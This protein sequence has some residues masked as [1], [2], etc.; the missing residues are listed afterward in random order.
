MS[1]RFFLTAAWLGALTWPVLG[2]AAAL[3]L[4]LV[5][6]L[7]PAALG[8]WNALRRAAVVP[9]RGLWAALEAAS[10]RIPPRFQIWGLAAFLCVAPLFLRHQ[11]KYINL[12]TDTLIMVLLALGLNIVLGMAGLFMLGYAAFYA[13][14]AYAFAILSLKFQVPFW[15]GLVAGAAAAALVG[16]VV[17]LPSLRLRGDYLAIVTLGLGETIRYII[18]NEEWLTGGTFGC[19]SRPVFISFGLEPYSRKIGS[20]RFFGWPAAVESIHYYFLALAMVALSVV[21]MQR[22]SNSRIGR[23]WVA[24]REDETAAQA[25]GVPTVWAKLSAFT[26]SAVWAGM[27]GVLYAAKQKF[28][29]PE[30]FDFNLSALVLSMV[31]LGGMGSIPGVVLGAV[32]LQMIPWFLR[33]FFPEFQ[34]YRLLIYGGL[35][36]LMM[37][38]RPQGLW[39]NTRRKIELQEE[40][41]A[42]A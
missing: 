26:L 5:V 32:V 41:D 28:L 12:A 34:N 27:A 36:V 15:G 18:K 13:I 3:K 20:P 25:A 31:V 7:I 11:T 33:D 4:A 23:A 2:T 39:P 9:C 21:A 8:C 24:L 17:G 35:M 29:A 6:S 38:W 22:L 42:V 19:P 14:G 37:I 40:T 1:R 10:G 16:F 30:I